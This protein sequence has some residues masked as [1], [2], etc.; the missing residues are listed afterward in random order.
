[1]TYRSRQLPEPKRTADIERSAASR[2]L[3]LVRVESFGD[4]YGDPRSIGFDSSVGFQL[5][6]SME[7]NVRIFAGGGGIARD[8]EPLDPDW[9]ITGCLTI[10]DT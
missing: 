5:C 10:R 7:E 1:M 3:C 8:K 6:W 9:W 2:G 4:E